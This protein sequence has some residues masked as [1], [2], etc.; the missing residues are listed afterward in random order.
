MS[1]QPSAARAIIH[2][3]SKLGP[4][5][6]QQL[7]K[8]VTEFP[9]L[10][11]STY[12]K[13]KVLVHMKGQ[14]LITKRKPR[15]EELTQLGYPAGAQKWLWYLNPKKIDSEKYKNMPHEDEVDDVIKHVDEGLIKKADK[16]IVETK[17]E[18]EEMDHGEEKRINGRF[19]KK[20]F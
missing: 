19:F 11:S 7:H 14:G 17:P 13:R 9:A 15:D 8:H 6:T 2:L 10:G 16:E 1:T 5:T 4:Q 12:L 3:L 20:L 18:R